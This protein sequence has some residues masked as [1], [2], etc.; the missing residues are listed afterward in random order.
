LPAPSL[1][2]FTIY[3]RAGHGSQGA[4]QRFE[5]GEL[6]F[7]DFYEAF[8]R[9]LSDVANGNRWQVFDSVNGHIE[10]ASVGIGH[11]VPKNRF[12]SETDIT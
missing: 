11:I 7:D 2:S 6:P 5:R 10:M 4:W 12:V 1:S 8:G 3:R 9:D